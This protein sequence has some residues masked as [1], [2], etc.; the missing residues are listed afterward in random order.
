MHMHIYIHMCLYIYIYYIQNICVNIYI[1]IIQYVESRYC[2]ILHG[3]HKAF[4]IGNI[5]PSPLLQFPAPPG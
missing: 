2:M 1:Y 3:C 4:K 5:K